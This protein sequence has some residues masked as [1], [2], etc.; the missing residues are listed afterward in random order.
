VLRYVKSTRNFGISYL[1]LEKRQK[2][3]GYVDSDYAGDRTDRK[4]T[5]RAIFMFLGGLLAW[6]SRKQQSVST[7]TTKVEY[8]ALC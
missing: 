8:V 7:S 1:G 2:V 4:S 5:Y 6:W 3:E